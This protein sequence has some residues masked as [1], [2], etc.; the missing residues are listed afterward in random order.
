MDGLKHQRIL[1]APVEETIFFA[2][3][4]LYEGLEIGTVEAALHSG[5]ETAHWIIAGS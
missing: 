4:G 3:E 1:K 2:G 5:R